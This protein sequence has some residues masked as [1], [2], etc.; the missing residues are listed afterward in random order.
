[1]ICEA[2]R[3]FNVSRVS[4]GDMEWGGGGGLPAATRQK[5]RAWTC[6]QNR[7]VLEMSGLLCE[8][9]RWVGM[10][11]GIV[12]S[13]MPLSVRLSAVLKGARVSEC[14]SEHTVVRVYSSLPQ[15]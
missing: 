10:E 13:W 9:Q 6:E 14:S 3:V 8:S 7:R 15:D 5:R 11:S 12:T 2:G 1:M 4:A